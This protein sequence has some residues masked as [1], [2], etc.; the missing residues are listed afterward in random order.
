MPQQASGLLELRPASG[1]ERLDTLNGWLAASGPIRFE[2]DPGAS[3]FPSGWVLI[4][5]KVSRGILD[6][7]ATLSAHTGER[8]VKF[9]VPVSLAGT[10]FELVKLPPAIRR[11]VWQPSRLAGVFRHTPLKVRKVGLFERSWLMAR[12][13]AVLSWIEPKHRK[14]R[15][16]LSWWRAFL[17]LETQYRAAGRLRS[18]VHD[19]PY[20][21]WI[22]RFDQR[23]DQD[24]QRI[25]ASIERMKGRPKFM[26]VAADNAET[27]RSLEGQ[28][29]RDFSVVDAA[30]PID[31]AAYV[32]V[33]QAGD[34]L[35]EH[36]LYWMAAAIVEGGDVAMAYAD[37]DVIDAAGLRSGPRFK[38]DW[39]PEHLR[40]INYVGRW[41]VIRGR[42]LAAAGGL[43]PESLADD[44]R[45]LNLRVA[46]ALRGKVAHVPA[47]LYHRAAANPPTLPAPRA[48]YPLPA[49]PPLVSIVIPTRDSVALLRACIDSIAAKSTCRN[50]EILVVD[51]QSREPEALRYLA[52]LE[53]R[54]LRYDREFNYSAINNLAAREARG[55]VLLL[56]NND[57][58]VITPDWLEEML[59]HLH[60]EGVGAVGAKLLFPY[61]RVQHAGDAVGP[62][63][64]ADH[65]HVDIARDDPGYC[66]R[67]VVAQEVSA[68]TGACLMTWKSLYQRLGGLDEQ[69]LPVAFNDVDYCL[70]IQEAGLRVIF[71]PHAELYHRESA[72]R[73]GRSPDREAGVMR[74]RWRTRMR[75]DPYYN[76][77]LSY[78][79][80]DFSLGDMPRVKRPW[81]K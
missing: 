67:A 11:L 2:L 62:G 75:H 30:A 5:G 61:G 45:E 40:S 49:K 42:E 29:Y 38:P 58:E 50:Y 31:P 46:K 16:G 36:A 19:M 63:G 66:H 1:L 32:C 64:C 43:R 47:V 51:N 77:N 26:I 70:R 3:G 65:M 37:E 81:S 55:E 23:T 12:R 56:L 71:T 69:R 24:R 14:K 13:V 35:A 6:R 17:D 22:E 20:G 72:S 41:A 74:R 73:G 8:E 59:G 60:Q 4:S 79:S 54:V 9:E 57:T 25:R 18:Y 34:R 48:R 27:K 33:L 15:A 21:E 10:V 78:R 39:S 28:L 52:E 53:H 80:P 68:V 76:P 7:S 44:G